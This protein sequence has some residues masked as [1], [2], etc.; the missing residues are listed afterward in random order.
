MK[1]LVG[2]AILLSMAPLAA[3]APTRQQEADYVVS[4]NVPSQV[5]PASDGRILNDQKTHSLIRARRIR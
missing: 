1:P 3:Q 5:I 4:C 2:L